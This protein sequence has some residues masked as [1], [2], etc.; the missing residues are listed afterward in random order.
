VCIRHGADIKRCG[1]QGCTNHIVK[2]GLCIRHGAKITRKRCSSEG[3]T[4][5]A[6]KGGVCRRHGAYSNSHD[7]STAFTSCVGS[8]FDKTTLTHPNQRTSA[9]RQQLLQVQAVFLERWSYV[10]LLQR[11]TMRRSRA[12]GIEVVIVLK[13][14]TATPDSNN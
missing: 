1:V 10:A 9:V 3:C 2:G 6:K 14:Y 5:Q 13:G 12:A 4:N 8:E 7:E 11:I